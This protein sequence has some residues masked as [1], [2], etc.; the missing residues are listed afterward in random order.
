[1]KVRML[2]RA[3][4]LRKIVD[5]TSAG[6]KL[7]LIGFIQLV[8]AL[9][10]WI[11]GDTY[12]ALAISIGAFIFSLGMIFE[13]LVLFNKIWKNIYGKFVVSFFFAFSQH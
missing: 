4:F 7:Y 6:Q 2:K 1:M 12:A 10:T 5:A 11:F 9:P 13:A 3:K 8:M